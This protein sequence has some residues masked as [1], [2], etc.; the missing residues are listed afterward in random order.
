MTLSLCGLV[1]GVFLA[2][3]LEAQTVQ[4][5]TYS[6]SGVS[7]TVMVPDRGSAFLGGIDRAQTGR[8]ESGV[9][10][11]PMVPFRSRS[12][13]QT[14]SSSNMS[15]TATIHDFDAMDQ[16]LL[17]TPTSGAVTSSRTFADVPAA[18]A[19]RSLPP[20]NPNLAGNW[21]PN[22]AAGAAASPQT[23]GLAQEQARRAEQKET[24][25]EEAEGFFE[26]AQQA[27]ADGKPNVARIYYQMVARRATGDL[28]QQALA[29]LDV[30]GRGVKVAQAKP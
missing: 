8:T 11:L 25:A 5:P 27:E 24:R 4:L 30:V 19:A 26:R 9:P 29:R 28:K 3:T 17:N 18:V 21:Q 10:M 2:E 16:A 1:L 13:G 22:P 14:R 7:T 23:G 20:R 15:V 6:F 12:I